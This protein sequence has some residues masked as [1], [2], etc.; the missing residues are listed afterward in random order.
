MPVIFRTITLFSIKINSISVDS[1]I[2]P[3]IHNSDKILRVCRRKLLIIVALTKQY[4]K[5]NITA[6]ELYQQVVLIANC[7]IQCVI[8]FSYQ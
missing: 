4:T 1:E 2:H 5:N 7:V 8:V 3:L 6:K